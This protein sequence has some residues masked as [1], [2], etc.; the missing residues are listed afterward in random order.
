MHSTQQRTTAGSVCQ[1]LTFAERADAEG[2]IRLLD[3]LAGDGDEAAVA[4]AN[5]A[6]RTVR[7][8]KHEYIDANHRA[9]ELSCASAV[10]DHFDDPLGHTRSTGSTPKPSR[11]G[12]PACEPKWAG[13]SN[14]RTR[15][16][17]VNPI[18][19]ARTPIVRPEPHLSPK[20]IRN[21]L[22]VTAYLLD[23]TET[24]ESLL[25][26]PAR[27]ADEQDPRRLSVDTARSR[28]R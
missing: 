3:V 4:G 26:A 14:T 21:L 12:W 27:V 22:A 2:F 10:R 23:R 11:H 6:V 28:C 8:V 24:V 5:L 18:R 17:T 1:S 7:E 19:A 15:Q 20:S 13:T 16:T 25:A 9:S